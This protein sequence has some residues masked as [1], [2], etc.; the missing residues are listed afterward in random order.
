VL[1]VTREAWST[2]ANSD[3]GLFQIVILYRL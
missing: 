2:T 3:T 1:K